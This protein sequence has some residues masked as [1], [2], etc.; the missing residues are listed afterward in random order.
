MTTKKPISFKLIL[1][2]LLVMFLLIGMYLIVPKNHHIDCRLDATEMDNG[3]GANQKQTAL[4]IVGVYRQ[5]LLGG[6]S[7]TGR[8]EID[9]YPVTCGE[10][11]PITFSSNDKGFGGLSYRND[12]T[13]EF[14]GYIYMDRK[15]S[16]VIVCLFDDIGGGRKGWSESTG[17]VI[18]F[19]YEK[20]SELTD[21]LY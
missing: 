1:A 2:V 11:L 19:P 12:G 4:T 21:K 14:I 13:L 16:E 7:F 5:S 3:S 9:G 6:D 17:S 8:V 15:A 10:M 20:I 18:S